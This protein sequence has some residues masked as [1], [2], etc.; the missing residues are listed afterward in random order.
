MLRTGV[1]LSAALALTVEDLDLDRGEALLR[2]SKGNRVERVFLPPA[3][4]EHLRRYLA[5][6]TTGPLFPGQ[7][8]QPV[9]ARHAHRR[10]KQWLKRSGA[11][12]VSPH[13]L[14]HT[15]AMGLYRRKRDLLLVRR[16]LGHR[17]LHST[18]RYAHVQ[19]DELREAMRRHQPV[20]GEA[21]LNV[22]DVG[23]G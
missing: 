8:G 23:D 18:L 1:R 3:V 14:R 6:R 22:A 2:R 10:L 20:P 15:F 16:A 12:S 17:S 4:Q 19:D 9:T 13:A 7:A 21:E 5:G 11:K